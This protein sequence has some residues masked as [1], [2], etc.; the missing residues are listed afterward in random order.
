MHPDGHLHQDLLF[1][2]FELQ[3]GDF[4]GG[5]ARPVIAAFCKA[6]GASTSPITKNEVGIPSGFGTYARAEIT[7]L[8]LSEAEVAQK[9]ELK[10]QQARNATRI[11]V[12]NAKLQCQNDFGFN[13]GTT[14]FSSCLME[15]QRQRFQSKLSA[16]AMLM[17]RMQV[18]ED[19]EMRREASDERNAI[20]MQNALTNALKPVAP[21]RS[22]INCT[23][24]TSGTS[25]YTN[26]N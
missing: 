23:S 24:N 5:F 3:P 20:G 1:R 6:K 11:E 4:F 10:N 2:F 19:R 9:N 12:E 15:M 18:E 7:F 25:T 21:A 13:P 17:Q 16:N 26:C 14:E 22:S 8:C